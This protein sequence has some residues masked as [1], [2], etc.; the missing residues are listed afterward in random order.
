MV[1]FD[2]INDVTNDVTNHFKLPFT[3]LNDPF[4]QSTNI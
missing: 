4:R 1:V 3:T 2:V